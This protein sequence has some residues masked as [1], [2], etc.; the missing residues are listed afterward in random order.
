MQG[1]DDVAADDA[2]AGDEARRR[3]SDEDGTR[4]DEGMSRVE[5]PC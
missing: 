5:V 2:E 3:Q 1:S 4:Q